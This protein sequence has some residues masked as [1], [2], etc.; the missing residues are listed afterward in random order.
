MAIPN[1]IYQ[2]KPISAQRGSESPRKMIL[3][4]AIGNPRH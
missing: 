3:P 2:I 4:D 1:L